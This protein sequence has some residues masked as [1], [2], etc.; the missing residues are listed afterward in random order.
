[1]NPSTRPP[2]PSGLPLVGNL[3]Q[4][5]RDPLNFMLRSARDYGDVVLFRLGRTPVYLLSHPAQVE[6]VLRTHA[7]D[8]VKDQMT[9]MLTSLIGNGLNARERF[10]GPPQRRRIRQAHIDQQITFVLRGN[11][12]CRRV[13]KNSIGREQESADHG[14]TKRRVHAR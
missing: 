3:L 1:M 13:D 4:Y 2:G 8:F 7:K 5:L 10:A 9:Q 6:Y 11:E 12:S 14:P